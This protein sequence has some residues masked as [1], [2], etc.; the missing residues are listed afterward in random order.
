LERLKKNGERT[1]EGIQCGK[2]GNVVSKSESE[3]ERVLP[4]SEIVN[5]DKEEKWRE[6]T[7][8]RNSS[9]EDEGL[10]SEAVDGKEEGPV[11]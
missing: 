5:E 10:R 3:R 9:P 1:T 6:N 11:R 7:P 4:L 8:L 2:E